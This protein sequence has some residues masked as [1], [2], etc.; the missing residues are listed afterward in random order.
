MNREEVL[1]RVR[2][3]WGVPPCD[4]DSYDCECV[5]QWYESED[6]HTWGVWSDFGL[7]PDFYYRPEEAEGGQA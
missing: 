3:A 5:P 7:L 6:G 4:H 2:I 1:D